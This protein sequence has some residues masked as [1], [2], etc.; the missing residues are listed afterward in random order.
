MT[1][2]EYAIKETGGYELP[3]DAFMREG[4]FV[5]YDHDCFTRIPAISLHVGRT[6]DSAPKVVGSNLIRRPAKVL[7]IKQ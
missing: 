2:P 7:R 6:V 1:L 5:E 4:D 3:V